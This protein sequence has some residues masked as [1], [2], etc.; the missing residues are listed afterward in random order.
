MNNAWYDAFMERLSKRHSKKGELAEALMDL[1]SIER[2]SAY[3]RLRREIIFP[4]NELVKIAL[5]WDISLDEVIGVESQQVIFKARLLN[6]IQSSKEDIESMQK[7]IQG[8]HALTNIPDLEYLEVCNKMP[9][10]LTA[11]FLYLRRFQLLEWMYQCTN[12][13]VRPFSQVAFLPEVAKLSSEYYVYIKKL[14][15]V[16]Y[17]WD[18]MLFDSVICS[19]RYF[20]SI[21]LITDEEKELIRNDLYAL[22]DYMSEVA[23]KGCWLET[24]NEVNLYISH[25]NIDTNYSYYYSEIVKICRVHAFAK[26]EIT[27]DN[28][29]IAEDF[30]NW[31]QLKKRSSVLIS[32]TNEKA[33]IEFF[34]KQRQ[35]VDE[36]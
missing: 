19:I 20:H 21:D 26:N 7:L 27:T 36:L 15:S 25:I 10:S 3:R 5:A 28:P 34:K 17:I 18:Y 12:E 9:R 22:I 35:L 14:P 24:G 2:E 11:G 33:R 29:V 8:L 32:E 13:E 16:S 23:V 31:M 6:Y 4:A 30:R 1:L